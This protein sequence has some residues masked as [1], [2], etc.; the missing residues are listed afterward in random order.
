MLQQR[1]APPPST[2]TTM[3]EDEHIT[4]TS[5][6]AATSSRVVFKDEEAFEAKRKRIIADGKDK[7]QV[8]SGMYLLGSRF[9]PSLSSNFRG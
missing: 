1:A 4:S 6:Q 7:F 8:I 2:A 9:Y 3:G 5:T